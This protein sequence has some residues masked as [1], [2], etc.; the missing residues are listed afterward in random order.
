[1][2]ALITTAVISILP[3][4]VVE[5]GHVLYLNVHP[6]AKDNEDSRRHGQNFEPAIYCTGAAL[7]ANLLQSY[8]IASEGLVMNVEYPGLDVKGQTSSRRSLGYPWVVVQS[9]NDEQ[10]KYNISTDSIQESNKTACVWVLDRNPVS[11]SWTNYTT[12]D[13]A[14]HVTSPYSHKVYSIYN[15]SDPPQGLSTGQAGDLA[16]LAGVGNSNLD[17]DY[18]KPNPTACGCQS[19]PLGYVHVGRYITFK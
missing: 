18:N 4:A 13:S 1:M 12:T 3:V 9:G 10:R 7:A 15:S 14:L 5:P 19:N 8:S 17:S 16:E 2:A 11:C 6:S